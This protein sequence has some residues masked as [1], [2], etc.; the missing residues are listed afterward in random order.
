MGSITSRKTWP[1][2]PDPR[3]G[4]RYVYELVLVDGKWVRILVPRRSD[5]RRKKAGR[6]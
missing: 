1:P 5:D 4:S 3:L 2:E 6:E